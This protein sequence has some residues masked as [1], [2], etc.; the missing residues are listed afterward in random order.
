MVKKLLFLSALIAIAVALSPI[1]ADKTTSQI[2]SK[3]NEGHHREHISFI[4][5]SPF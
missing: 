4:C 3:V 1:R 5:K 2:A